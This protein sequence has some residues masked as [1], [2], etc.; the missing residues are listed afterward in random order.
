MRHNIRAVI[1]M[2]DRKVSEMMLTHVLSDMEL[3]DTCSHTGIDIHPIECSR[4][5]VIAGERRQ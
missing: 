2:C 4:D 5:P 3:N 1:T